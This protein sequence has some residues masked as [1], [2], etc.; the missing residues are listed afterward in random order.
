M[1]VIAPQPPLPLRK[2]QVPFRRHHVVSWRKPRF[3]TIPRPF[4]AAGRARFDSG[5][6]ERPGNDEL[7]AQWRSAARRAGDKAQAS[8]VDDSS[9]SAGESAGTAIGAVGSLLMSSGAPALDLERGARRARFATVV[10]R[11]RHK[12][13]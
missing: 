3:S 11:L 9:T 13:A 6:A 12:S 7:D 1:R 2:S 5:Q 10:D 4:A 8:L